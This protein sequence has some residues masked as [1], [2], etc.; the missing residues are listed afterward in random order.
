MY[1]RQ[2]PGD[3]AWGARDVPLQAQCP[4]VWAMSA[5]TAAAV[6][7]HGH[8]CPVGSVAFSDEPASDAGRRGLVLALSV[9]ALKSAFSAATSQSGQT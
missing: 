1:F 7:T 8:G 4:A 9:I 3:S 2:S 6:D 5:S